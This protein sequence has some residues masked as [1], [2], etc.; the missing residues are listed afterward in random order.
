M[1]LKNQY[2]LKSYIKELCQPNSDFRKFIE[3]KK[4]LIKEKND[5]DNN[6]IFEKCTNKSIDS[7]FLGS[8]L[9]DYQGFADNKT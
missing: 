8:S 9:D 4:D 1:V 5:L 3:V 6:S 7:S 2:K